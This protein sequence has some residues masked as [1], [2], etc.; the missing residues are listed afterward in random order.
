[1]S[2]DSPRALQELVA[3]LEDAA[4]SLPQ[5]IQHYRIAGADVRI[6]VGTRG[7]AARLLTAL[8]PLRASGMNPA[9]PELEIFVWDGAGDGVAVPESVI[10]RREAAPAGGLGAFAHGGVRAFFQPDAGVLS[11]FDAERRRAWCWWRDAA[12]VPYYEHAAP[13]RHILQWWMVARGGALLHSSAVGTTRGGILIVG[14]SGS[15]KSSTALACLEAGLGFAS[16]DY[17]LVDGSEPAQVHLAYSTAKIVRAS[18]ERHVRYRGHFRNLE[19]V[20]EKPMMFMHEVAPRQVLASFPLTALVLPVI[21]RGA[22]TRIVPASSAELLRALA[23][24]SILLFPL[25]GA[26]AF[27]RIARLCRSHPCYRAELSA[28][29]AEVADALLRWLDTRVDADAALSP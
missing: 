24:S 5:S 20:D 19:H 18:L 23:P 14:P 2:S 22:R 17:V 21:A 10:T 8:A 7:C 11:V 12:S 6:R 29:P 15:G 9:G 4:R 13:M 27:E 28:D 25:A 3:R 26:A 1:M 16:D